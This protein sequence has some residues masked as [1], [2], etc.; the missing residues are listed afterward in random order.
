MSEDYQ[1]MMRGLGGQ[2]RH[3]CVDLPQRTVSYKPW[4]ASPNSDQPVPQT[5]L[6]PIVERITKPTVAS[7][8]GVDLKDKD[9]E[10]MK[11]VNWMKKTNPDWKIK[12]LDTRF[13]TPRQVS[14]AE[15][16]EIVDRL[17]RSTAISR[18]RSAPPRLSWYPI[19]LE[20]GPVEKPYFL[21]QK[22]RSDGLYW[23]PNESESR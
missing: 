19:N 21:S 8:G 18:I 1:S 7:R 20:K 4:F 22:L 17:A 9:F 10:Y 12:N 11:P 6:K 23:D 16:Q 2:E 3:C 15:F 14:K 5:Q 13:R